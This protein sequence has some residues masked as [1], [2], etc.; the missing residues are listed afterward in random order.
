MARI[1]IED[2]RAYIEISDA[3]MKGV[4]GG[5][6]TINPISTQ[7][8]DCRQSRSENTTAF[9]NFDQKANQLFNLLS[10]VMRSLK[11][12]RLATTLNLL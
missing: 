8:E 3:E 6:S 4:F 12:M 2:L 1:K 10:T 9:E 5:V 11:E 7:M